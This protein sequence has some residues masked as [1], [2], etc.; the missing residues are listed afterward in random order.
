MS[1]GP[2]FGAL[3]VE[4]GEVLKATLLQVA[5]LKQVKLLEIGMHSGATAKGIKAF[6]ESNG[7]G[8]EYWSID[9][10]YLCVV[11]DP[12]PGARVTKGLSDEVY[13]SIPNDFDVIFVDGCHCRNHVILDTIHYSPKVKPGGFLMFHDCSP[14][15]QGKD[16]Q[17]HGPKTNEFCIDVLRGLQRINFPW[18]QWTLFMEKYNPNLPF[19]GVRSY[20]KSK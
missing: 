11:S 8:L 2:D 13:E 20:R 16:Q 1:Y 3:T 5:P 4:D 15:A 14:S 10:G 17:Y 9:P 7:C 12:F 6:L 19:G 18:P